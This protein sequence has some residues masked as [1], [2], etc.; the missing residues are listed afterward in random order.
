LLTS[1][2]QWV[3][4]THRNNE[5]GENTMN[6]TVNARSHYDETYQQTHQCSS[7]EEACAVKSVYEEMGWLA[8][9]VAA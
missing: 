8:T 7:Y 2:T 9:I 4:F 1:K 3:T 6:Y 5:P